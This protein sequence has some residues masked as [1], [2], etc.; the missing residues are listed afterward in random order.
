[1]IIRKG[2]GGNMYKCLLVS[3]IALFAIAP[4]YCEEIAIAEPAIPTAQAAEAMTPSLTC[5]ASGIGATTPNARMKASWTQNTYNLEWYGDDNSSTPLTVQNSAQSCDYGNALVLPSTNPTKV[6]YTFLGWEMQQ[7]QMCSLQNL[8][9]D[10]YAETYGYNNNDFGVSFNHGDILGEASCNT[11]AGT[12]AIEGRRRYVIFF[13]NIRPSSTFSSDTNTGQYCWCRVKTYVPSGG[14]ECAV[15]PAPWVF[16]KDLGGVDSC[17]N[18]CADKCAKITR[19]GNDD[20]QNFDMALFGQYDVGAT[21]NSSVELTVAGNYTI[22]GDGFGCVDLNS[23]GDCKAEINNNAS[24]YGIIEPGQWGVG[25]S[26]GLITGRALCSSTN[27]TYATTGTPDTNSSGRYCWCRATEYMLTRS[28]QCSLSSPAWVFTKAYDSVASC[29][30]SCA[31]NCTDKITGDS[32]L[33]AVL[34][35]GTGASVK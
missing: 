28:N 13:S 3:I 33:R 35:Y 31:Y 10:N 1:M 5:D 17:S 14:N 9:I 12:E 8:E 29:S 21:C 18:S 27:G 7:M 19:N 26:F 11:T 24:T 25:F 30:Y 15:S 6:G 23:D 20:G 16:Y 32:G 2:Q 22:N 34:F 4:V